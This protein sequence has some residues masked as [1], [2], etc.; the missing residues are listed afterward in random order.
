MDQDKSSVAEAY[1][2]GRENAKKI[3]SRLGARKIGRSSSNEYELNGKHIV[4]KSARKN[5]NDIGVIYSMLE[6]LDYILGSFQ[7][8]DGSYIIYKLSP[9]AFSRSMKLITI[10][11]GTLEGIVGKDVFQSVGRLLYTLVLD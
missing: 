9:V 1:K 10:R 5:N 4:I 7:A 8:E 6:R 11:G 3:A 2:Y